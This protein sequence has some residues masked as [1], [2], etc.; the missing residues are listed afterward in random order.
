MQVIKAKELFNGIK[1][2]ENTEFD[3]VDFFDIDFSGVNF[4]DLKAV[5]TLLNMQK[6]AVL[7]NKNILAHN[8][9]PAV[10]QMLE[11]TGLNKNF[12]TNPIGKF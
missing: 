1:K 10:S 5:N 4:I 2:L 11:L 12:V 3:G 7:N 6:I 9:N 8:V